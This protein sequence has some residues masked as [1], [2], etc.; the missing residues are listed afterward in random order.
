MN[1]RYFLTGIAD[2]RGYTPLPVWVSITVVTIKL[3]QHMKSNELQTIQKQDIPKRSPCNIAT[4][5]DAELLNNLLHANHRSG[6]HLNSGE[7][8]LQTFGG[9][10]GLNIASRMPAYERQGLDDRC[11][12]LL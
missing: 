11:A 10:R 5:S 1:A 12:T 6:E 4:M 2:K 7:S 3:I 8:L 9:L